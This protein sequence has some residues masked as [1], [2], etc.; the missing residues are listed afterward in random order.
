MIRTIL[1]TVFLILLTTTLTYSQCCSAGNPSS[2][3]FGDQT[4]LK[5]KSLLISS[6]FKYGFSDT[7]F[8]GDKPENMD[9][10][11]PAS[12]TFMDMKAAFGINNRFTIQAETGFFFSKQQKNPS[13]Y[14]PYRGFGLGD[15][16]ANVRYRFY[17]S[18]KHRVEL[19][20]S[21]GM[22]LPIGVF[23]QEKD[24]VELPISL[25]PSSGSLVY[26]GGVS[27]SKLLNNSKFQLYSSAFAEF[28]QLIDSKNFYYRYGNLYNISF[29]SAYKV[30][31]LFVPTLQIQG[32]MRG[33]DTRE[34]EQVVDASGYKSVTLSPQIESDFLK[35][36]SVM[37]YTDLPVYRYFNG[38][39]MANKF[40]AG[41]RLAKKFS[42]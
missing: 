33:H 42:L 35:N 12:F 23:D 8:N 27:F 19:I 37:I 6:S 24:G 7:Y 17:K 3:S 40:K 25:Q 10:Y 4:A 26:I 15:A 34:D 20:A 11:T 13:P 22:R 16:A 38:L 14:P 1:I 41:V 30:H 28:P 32:E 2:F 36:W 29:A 5:A 21:L 9:F 31:R 39:Q 18:M